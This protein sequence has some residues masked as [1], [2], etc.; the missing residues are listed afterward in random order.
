MKLDKRFPL[1]VAAIFIVGLA[2]ALY[3]ASAQGEEV[4]RAVVAGAILST[5]NVLAGY[6][7]IEVSFE[8]SHTTFLKAVLGGM[9]IR[10][11]VMLVLI[12]AFVRLGGFHATAL[13]VSVLGFYVVY[14]VLE[15]FYIQRKA[16]HIAR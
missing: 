6:L 16:S 5:L 13:V 1:Q 14:L 9:G 10:V 3:V 12:V 11:G 4:S 2:I 8:K 15:L 7:A